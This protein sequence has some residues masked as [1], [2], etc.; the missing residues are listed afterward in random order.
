[1]NGECT[2][3]GLNI[4]S[5]GRARRQRG[6]EKGAAKVYDDFIDTDRAL[7]GRAYY[8]LK[9]ITPEEALR[10]RY[11]EIEEELQGVVYSDG[12]AREAAYT[13]MPLRMAEERE[14]IEEAGKSW[15]QQLEGWEDA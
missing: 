14:Q 13:S 9:R 3:H 8:M 1:M 2:E 10:L 12:L 5:T 11:R 4:R 6:E 15:L 7:M